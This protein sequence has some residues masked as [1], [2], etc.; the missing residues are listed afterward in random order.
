[1]SNARRVLRL[2]TRGSALARWQ[3]EHVRDLLLR[4]RPD[5]PAEIVVLTTSG[6]RALDTP[7]AAMGGKGAFTA[8]LEQAL[9][10][11]TIDLAVH[12]LKDLPTAESEGLTIGAIIERADPSDLL[13]T[14][15]D[16]T[17]ATLPERATLG[18]SSRRRSAQLLR[19]RPDLTILD[20]RGNVDTRLRKAL[21]PDGPYDGVVLAQAGIERL[22]LVVEHAK[23]LSFY[24][25]LPAPGQGALAVQ[26][27]DDAAMLALLAPLNH[28]PTALAVAAER[29]FLAAL[30][31]GCATPVSALGAVEGDHLTLRV[32]VTR[33]DGREQIDGSGRVWA[34]AES[35]RALGEQLAA[36]V[37][38]EGGSWVTEAL[39]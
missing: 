11:G 26:C 21:D 14:R 39:T 30:G 6:D 7:L 24:E 29:A 15:S 5:L 18:T 36:G 33:P 2:G 27:L 12:S 13:I 16:L 37:L 1:M 22:G 38:R 19:Q 28:V 8:E 32:R 17:L 35:A 9:R 25:M 23:R 3:T 34:R 4:S 31:G 20:I 10:A